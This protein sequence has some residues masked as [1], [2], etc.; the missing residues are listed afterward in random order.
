MQIRKVDVTTARWIA[1]QFDTKPRTAAILAVVMKLTEEREENAQAV[2][3]R[4]VNLR[5]R[6]RVGDAVLAA[7]LEAAATEVRA[8]RDREDRL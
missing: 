5:A 8:R 3:R 1:W 6:G 4:A 7:E 2:E